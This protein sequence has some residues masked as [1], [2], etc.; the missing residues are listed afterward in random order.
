M[1][2]SVSWI[3]SREIGKCGGYD[4]YRRDSKCHLSWYRRSDSILA[5]MRGKRDVR[6]SDRWNLCVSVGVFLLRGCQQTV[7]EIGER[8]VRPN[9]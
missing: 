8:N 7:E 2:M 5:K 1:A 9:I 6:L 3:L 4:G